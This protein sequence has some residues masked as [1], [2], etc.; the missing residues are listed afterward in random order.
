[1]ENIEGWLRLVDSVRVWC[2]ARA[3]ASLVGVS[4]GCRDVDECTGRLVGASEGCQDVDE[5]TGRFKVEEGMGGKARKEVRGKASAVSPVWTA[6]PEQFRCES[7]LA[8]EPWP[9]ALGF[10][11]IPRVLCVLSEPA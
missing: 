7:T 4:E 1:M 2:T 5:H 3:M 8:T 9:V 10:E 6:S 11:Q